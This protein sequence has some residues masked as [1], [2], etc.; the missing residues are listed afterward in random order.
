MKYTTMGKSGLKVSKV[1]LGTMNFAD[2]TNEKNS[3][4][5]MDAALERGINLFDSADFYG[6]PLGQG[7]TEECVGRWLAQGGRRDK[8]ILATKFCATMNTGVND[9]GASAYHV[10]R[11]CED[12]LR[13]L[14]TDHIDL[15]QAHHYDR[16]VRARGE[17]GNIGLTKEFDLVPGRRGDYETPF[18]ET[19]SAFELLC[20]NGK[21][22]Y[23]GTCNFPGWGIARIHSLARE[24]H[25]YSLISEQFTINL[26]NRFTEI[27]L[28]PACRH[29]GVGTMVYSPLGRGLLCGKNS[30]AV[31]RV[32]DPAMLK[33]LNRYENF[34]NEIGENPDAVALAWVL[35]NPDVSTVILGPRTLEQ[36]ESNLRALDVTLTSDMLKELDDIWPGVLNGDGREAPEFY[37]W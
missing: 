31:Q 4:A 23:A 28:L 34:C 6:N 21:I 33:T 15:F 13:R 24:M 3:F 30:R 36:F 8:I 20:Y 32:T 5:I 27:E 17:L 14:R 18:E 12:S 1:C 2:V 26:A 19:L 25:F 7:L 22:T 29:M 35:A 37:A 9:R 16:G 11:A 10:K